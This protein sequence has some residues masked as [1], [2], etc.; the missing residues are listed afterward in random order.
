MVLM[1]NVGPTFIYRHHCWHYTR[2]FAI[3]DRSNVVRMIAN[4]EAVKAELVRFHCTSNWAAM[5]SSH[6]FFQLLFINHP[7]LWHRRRCSA[8]KCVF[9]SSY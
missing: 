5:S 7:I 8:I 9:R 1:F 4:S 6:I 3:A 2:Q